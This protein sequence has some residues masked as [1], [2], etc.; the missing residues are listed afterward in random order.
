[1]MALFG[2]VIR[3]VADLASRSTS[4]TLRPVSSGLVVTPV[5]FRLIIVPVTA[6]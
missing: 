1:M 3:L 4:I 2:S 5:T 6:V